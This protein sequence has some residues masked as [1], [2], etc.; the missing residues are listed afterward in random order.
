MVFTSYLPHS[1]LTPMARDRRLKE[2]DPEIAARIRGAMAADPTGSKSSWARAAGVS[3]ST[4]Y[5]YALASSDLV[6]NAAEGKAKVKAK[7]VEQTVVSQRD[8]L[9]AVLNSCVEV[10][11]VID[12]L[13]CMPPSP[14]TASA[15]FKGHGTLERYRR[16]TGDLAGAIAPP[17]QSIYIQRVTALLSRDVD[18]TELSDTAR[19][20]L[21]GG[22]DGRTH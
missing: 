13:R 19:Q 6:K 21:N 18:L 17:Q 3:R 10:Q 11:Q 16:L 2:V 1:C 8:I 20:A 5:S 15:I 22:D 12:E 14:T 9:D 7:I 4:F